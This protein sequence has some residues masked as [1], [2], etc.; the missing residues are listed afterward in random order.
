MPFFAW[1]RKLPLIPDIIRLVSPIVVMTHLQP[2]S[3]SLCLAF[4]NVNGSNSPF[5]FYFL[6]RTCQHRCSIKRRTSLLARSTRMVS[7]P[8][9]RR[10]RPT[11]LCRRTMEQHSSIID[12]FNPSSFFFSFC[13]S[14]L[15]IKKRSSE[16]HSSPT[17]AI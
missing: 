8:P 10:R 12:H 3:L 4:D 9:R 7:F 11:C 2:L 15:L 17:G 1:Q 6:V 16:L 14:S 5:A 13:P